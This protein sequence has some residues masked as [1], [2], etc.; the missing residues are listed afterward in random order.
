MRTRVGV[1]GLNLGSVTYR[2][3]LP[4]LSESQ[5]IHP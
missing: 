4:D 3:R 1:S 2:G 5:F